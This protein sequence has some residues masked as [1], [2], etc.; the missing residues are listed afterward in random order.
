M[1]AEDGMVSE[2]GVPNPFF[3]SPPC[4]ARVEVDEVTWEE[5]CDEVW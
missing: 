2:M 3:P 4:R 1:G 5:G